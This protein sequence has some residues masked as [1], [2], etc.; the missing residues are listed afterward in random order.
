MSDKQNLTKTTLHGAYMTNN[1]RNL[2]ILAFCLL[3]TGCPL[4]RGTGNAV[5]AVGDGV[6]D[7]VQGTGQAIGQTG[8]ELADQR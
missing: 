7:A 5:E 6:G 1:Y 2:V 3:L 4:V 8:R